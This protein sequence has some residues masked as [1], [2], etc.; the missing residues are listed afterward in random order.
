MELAS[1]FQ[2]VEGWFG[3]GLK[4]VSLKPITQ[5]WDS[6]VKSWFQFHTYWLCLAYDYLIAVYTGERRPDPL[7]DRLRSGPRPEEPVHRAMCVFRR[8]RA[9]QPG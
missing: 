9:A 8:L 4:G 3:V 6:P 5:L 1:K 2:G 7:R